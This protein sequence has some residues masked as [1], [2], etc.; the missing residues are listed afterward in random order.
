MSG[1]EHGV[2]KVA[3]VIFGC[4]VGLLVSLL[5]AKVWPVAEPENR[6]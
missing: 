4:L 2:H 3:E 5:M 1:I 6:P